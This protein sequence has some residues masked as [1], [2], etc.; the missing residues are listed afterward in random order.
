[1]SR[2]VGDGPAGYGG[3]FVVRRVTGHA[4]RARGK[5]ASRNSYLR[6]LLGASALVG[7]GH[8]ALAAPPVLPQGGQFVAGAGVIGQT[9]V[10]ALQINQQSARG[11]IDWRSFS[12][13]QGGSVTINNGLGATLNRVIGGRAS[14]IEGKLS[15]TGSVYLVNPQGVVIG[16]GGKVVGGGNV[17]V[18][19][20]DI[21]NGAFMAGGSMTASGTS[22]GDLTN[23]GK[24]ISQQ[25]DVVLIGRS[26]TNSGT[27]KAPDGTV[28]LA[29]GDSV[30]MAAA[31][32]IG[33]VYVVPDASAAGDVTEEGRI[34][35]A[36]A[37]LTAAGGNVY[38]L[39][40][41]RRDL[42]EAGG[43]TTIAGQVWLS[44]PNGQVSAAGAV[45][46]RNVDGSGG[47]IFLHGGKSTLLTGSLDV[48][49]LKGGQIFVGVTG[50]QQ[51]LS[52]STTIADG[53]RIKAGGPDGGGQVETSGRLLSIGAA[54]V[55]TAGGQW[56][57][58]PINLTIDS[59]SGAVSTIVNALNSSDV[60]IQT[61]ASGLSDTGVSNSIGTQASGA[62]DIT[63]ASAINWSTSHS[64]TLQAYNN[65][66][67]NAAITNTATGNVT[68][69]AGA[70]VTIGAAVSGATVSVTA[71]G[72]D[73][74]VNG[75]GSVAGTASSGLAV[76]LK[77]T[78][79]FVNAGAVSVAAGANWRLYSTNP[80]LDTL[81]S[82]SPDFF[83]YNAGFGATPAASGNGALYS[84]AP[85][86]SYGLTGS[87]SKV[88]D[89]A[90]ALVAGSLTAANLSAT[91]LLAG[92]AA[93]P[94]DGSGSLSQ[95]DVG[96]SLLA[97]LNNGVSVSRGGKPVYGYATS[98]AIQGVIGSITPAPLTVDI[99]GA[100][101]KIYD[102]NDTALL[103]S[104]NFQ[105]S[106]VAPADTGSI[107]ISPGPKLAVYVGAS[108]SGNPV[109]VG[110]GYQL[111]VDLISTNYVV[112]NGGDI[113]LTNYTLPTR[114]ENDRRA[115][116]GITPYAS[117][118][119][120]PAPLQLLGL[121]AQD[122]TYDAT[123]AATV[124]AAGLSGVVGGDNVTLGG[125]TASFDNGGLAASGVH[126]TYSATLA[127]DSIKIGD[128]QVVLPSLTADIAK[129]PLTING[130]AVLGGGKVYDGTLAAII[131]A[132]GGQLNTSQIAV[133][134][135]GSI[136][137]D[138]S[139]VT[140]QYA[141][142][143]VGQ[144]L[145]VTV[146]PSSITLTG[147]GV[148]YALTVPTL[149]G[150]I[151][152]RQLTVSLGTDAASK[153]YDGN[154]IAAV[155]PSKFSITGWV[156]G[157]GSDVSI[158]QT[159]SAFFTRGGANQSN[160]GTYDVTAN[161][162]VSDF[163]AT[164]STK[165]SNYYTTMDAPGGATLSA[166]VVSANGGVI[167][168]APLNIQLVGNPTKTYDGSTAITLGA[169]NF[170]ISGFVNG[171]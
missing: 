29:A 57:L 21:S 46:A 36:A 2:L 141:Q 14:D 40:G 18:S 41:N 89:G 154:A 159:A 80:N 55:D 113:K 153:T 70:G 52:D 38:T 165:L 6:G 101:T 42:I 124:T 54:S 92:D 121:T 147:R 102:G 155:D 76:T 143:D 81:G 166:T 105:V 34:K 49:G 132:T 138:A 72:G 23:L 10:G 162:T 120:T 106:G 77:T 99:V 150:N 127:G 53:A 91:G 149:F 51:G 96:A 151:T 8:A 133:S 11:V 13:G 98:G 12:I 112:S 71:N 75:G 125:V 1:M 64:L 60:T 63:V 50:P 82:L 116:G 142:A 35:A 65:L 152:P 58:D 19:S 17:V 135:L 131:D 56:L 4:E 22:P 145:T 109:D 68:L 31:N 94:T 86:A 59:G 157:E 20:R 62:G 144:G 123:N 25:G 83:Q 148:N 103:N 167:N 126:V 73:L 24:I 171:E 164:G 140:A 136:G 30:L 129:A 7:A 37:A 163:K 67:V 27:I 33:G 108:G 15:A 128:Y 100:V 95:S 32:G 26:V 45:V 90:T 111:T 28:N 169:A 156:T 107:L 16:P 43:A 158:V 69:T 47:Q 66:N 160:A 122:K 44:A 104:T 97:T 79:K 48:S 9:G 118:A 85:S 78:G 146:D 139:H 61:N 137:F 114:P 161:V 117:A 130:L 168:A 84:V 3:I 5:A 119:I 134:D 87:V 170:Q 74:T 93:A 115:T 110:A 39:A 88:Y